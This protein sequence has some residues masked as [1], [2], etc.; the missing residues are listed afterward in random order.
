MD[1]ASMGA[2][3]V[4]S[5]LHFGLQSIVVCDCRIELVVLQLDNHPCHFHY[6]L[7]RL[8]VRN[9]LVKTFLDKREDKLANL[10]SLLVLA[11][12]S[13]KGVCK[14]LVDTLRVKHRSVLECRHRNKWSSHWLPVCHWSSSS[15]MIILGAVRW[16]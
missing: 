9:H 4:H 8:V 6:K 5:F 11:D 14:Q 7:R 1:I 16:S 2:D 3:Q 12:L 13:Q 15:K 10:I